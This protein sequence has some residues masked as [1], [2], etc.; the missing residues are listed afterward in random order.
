MDFEQDDR[1]ELD[2]GV[3]RRSWASNSI[4]LKDFMRQ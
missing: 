4:K 1:L 2:V 3:E